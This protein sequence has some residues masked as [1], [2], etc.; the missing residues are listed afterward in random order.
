MGPRHRAVTPALVEAVSPTVI[1]EIVTF[2]GR[3]VFAANS[4]LN[5]MHVKYL[6]MSVV[7]V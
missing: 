4:K 5:W 1:T 3:V 7:L 6:S 2:V